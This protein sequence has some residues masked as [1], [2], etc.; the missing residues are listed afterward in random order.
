MT[1]WIVA[2]ALIVFGV[3]GG[4]SIGQPFLLIGLAMVL[5]GPFRSRRAVFS[6]LMSAV[7][8]FVVA[9]V[10]RRRTNSSS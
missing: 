7:V 3:V 10:M 1:Y 4:F 2:V 5:L 9:T 6:P 8:A